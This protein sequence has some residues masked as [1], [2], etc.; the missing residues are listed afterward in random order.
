MN[1][2]VSKCYRTETVV[3]VRATVIVVEIEHSRIRTIVEVTTTYKEWV[4]RVREV[5]VVRFN[6]N[7]LPFQSIKL[8]G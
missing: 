7:I 1:L 4:S 6:P 2:C 8:K 5:R 3:A